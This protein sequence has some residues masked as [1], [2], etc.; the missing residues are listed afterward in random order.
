MTSAS[1]PGLLD[2]VFLDRDGVLNRELGGYV[3]SPEALELLPGAADAVERLTARSIPCFVFTNQAVIGRGGMST[4][5]LLAIHDKLKREIE[6]AGGRLEGIYFCPHHPDAGCDCRKPLPGLL[7][8]AARDHD[9]DLTRCTVIGDSPR[10]IAAGR[11]AGCRTILVLTGHTRNM[12]DG[13]AGPLPDAVY[14]DLAA[15]IHTLLA[16]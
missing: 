4:E 6:A 9:L 1:P 10:D 12:A 8:Q 2:A 5:T 16:T 7:F 13:Y 3:T 11:A 15:A 14:P